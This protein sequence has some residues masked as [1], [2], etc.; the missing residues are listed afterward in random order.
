MTFNHDY[1]PTPV[2]TERPKV[3]GPTPFVPA[4]NRL[5]RPVR[6]NDLAHLAALLPPRVLV[7][8]RSPRTWILRRPISI[9][10][11]TVVSIRGGVVQVRPSAFIEAAD[12]GTLIMRRL[13]VRAVD[14]NGD[15]M[16]KP[17]LSRG[18][19]VARDGATLQLDQNRLI[20]LGH[21]GVVSYGLSLRKPDPSSFIKRCTVLRSYF[22]VYLSHASGVEIVDNKLVASW[23]YGIDPHTESSDLLIAGNTV[24]DSGTHAIVLADRVH[25]SAVRN[26]VIRGA[27]DHGI[28][29]FRD[30]SANRI[31]G[32][33]I[34]GVFDGIVITDSPE[35]TL[36]ANDVEAR[37]FALR[38]S[39]NT[40][41][42]N[43]ASQNT[44]S[45]AMVGAYLYHGA[46]KN[47]L[48]DNRFVRN[49]ENVRVRGDAPLNRVVPVPPRSEL[50]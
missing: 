21:L 42:E 45:D 13:V 14:Q 24:V 48:L 11:R 23:I 4:S 31:T 17:E 3:T 7:R 32:N 1:P 8:A 33:R 47:A 18:F 29:V 49:V 12:G 10:G 36:A 34:S 2:A 25:S 28:V 5:D 9:R 39:G 40:A 46:N 41:S 50:P 27:G 43:E 22:G 30:S 35:N 15:V 26:N 6:V 20:D 37:R 16:Q 44:F 19:I 38:V